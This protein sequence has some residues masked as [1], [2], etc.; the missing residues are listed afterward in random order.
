MVSDSKNEKQK[1][2]HQ[3]LSIYMNRELAKLKLKKT[4]LFRQKNHNNEQLRVWL[5]E[6]NEIEKKINE[7]HEKIN[8]FN[9]K[10]AALTTKITECQQKIHYYSDLLG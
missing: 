4:T 7:T 6:K 9:E 3:Q 2:K 8:N 5:N 1:S 10:V